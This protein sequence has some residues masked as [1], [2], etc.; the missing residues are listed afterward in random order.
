LP[1]ANANYVVDSTVTDGSNTAVVVEW[2]A[3]NKYLYTTKPIDKDFAN[4]ATLTEV[5]TG[6]VGTITATNTPGLEPYSGDVLYIENRSPISRSDDQIED[7]KLIV[8]F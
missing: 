4:A 5:G 6:T 2:D 7:V 1:D 3:T 8:E